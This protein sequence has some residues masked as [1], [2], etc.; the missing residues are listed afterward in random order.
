MIKMFFFATAVAFV[1]FASQ[2]E[3]PA[4]LIDDPNLN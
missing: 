2:E 3:T 1:V 4:Q